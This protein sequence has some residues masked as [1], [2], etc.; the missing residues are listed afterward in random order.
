MLIYG[1]FSL[2]LSPQGRGIFTGNL[3]PRVNKDGTIKVTGYCNMKSVRL[4]GSFHRVLSLNWG[5][6][7]HLVM[8]VRG[9]GRNYLI[10]LGVPGEFDIHWNDSY[11]YVLHTRGGPYWQFVRIPFSK[12][13]L[14]AKG[15]IQDTQQPVPQHNIK[16]FGLTAS[17]KIPGHFKLEIDYIG[18]EY[19]PSYTEEHAYEMYA[20]PHKF[21]I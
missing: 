20:T 2:Q 18:V 6:Y 3:D 21:H 15:R 7:T 11:Q 13:F 1:F 12:F 5:P 10:A 9:D 8:R 16:T 14:S 4:R 19:D 17:D